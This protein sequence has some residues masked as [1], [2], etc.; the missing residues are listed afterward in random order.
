MKLDEQYLEISDYLLK[1][2][3][4]IN[5]SITGDGVRETLKIINEFVPIEVKEVP[6]GTEVFDWKIPSEWNIKD[7]WIKNSNG[8]K[9]V[10]FKKNN[11]HVMGYSEPVSKKLTYDELKKHVYS[12]PNYPD[13]IPYRTSYYQKKWGFC[14]SHNT[15]LKLSK[16][17]EYEVFI[18]SKFNENGSLSYGEI[19][20]NGNGNNQYL[21]S[22]YIC[23]P[24]LANDNL[25]GVVLTT[26]LSNYL[27]KS[28]LRNNYKIIFIPETI[29]AITFLSQNLDFSKRVKGGFV[30][31]TVAGKGDFGY[32]ETFLGNSEIDQSVLL[33]FENKKLIRYPF[34]PNGSDERQFSSPGFRIPMGS[35]TKDKYYEYKEYHTSG[36]NLDF[37]SS[38]NLLETLGFYI[39]TI[40]NLERNIIY[41]RSNP[42]CEYQLGKYNL[43]PKTG[44]SLFQPS[45]KIDKKTIES[46][47]KIKCLEWLS[48][49]CDGEN[50]L[51]EISNKSK[52]DFNQIYSVA[53]E[54]EKKKLLKKI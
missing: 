13:L 12:L 16:N 36:D 2:L 8:E 40:K 31:T 7:G 41:Q 21:I 19:D 42:Y 6:S 45:G 49:L 51:M 10:D 48:F 15:F 23:H 43:Y 5:R 30:I 37:I 27:S 22:T 25:S 24:S 47:N 38:K 34:E 17:D 32:K 14:V 29:G 9:L 20:I 28:D 54:M 4:P 11:L 3:F 39:E 35:I 26:L 52:L 18:D 33:A 44:G 46:E 1:K 50:S 53:L